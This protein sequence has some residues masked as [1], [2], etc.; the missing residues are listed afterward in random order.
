MAKRASYYH[1]E[2]NFPEYITVNVSEGKYPEIVGTYFRQWDPDL[3]R[4]YYVKCVDFPKQEYYLFR[5]N[6]L[7]WTISEQYETNYFTIYYPRETENVLSCSSNWVG[8]SK[9]MCDKEVKVSINK[10]G[11]KPEKIVSNTDVSTQTD[12]TKKNSKHKRKKEKQQKNKVLKVSEN[13]TCSICFEEVGVLENMCK[14][15]CKH[16]FHSECILPWLLKN[17]N[18]PNCRKVVITNH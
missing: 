11:F 6:D 15:P 10:L 4:M 2:P 16:T 1:M 3:N 17:P 18:C 9:Y 7:M 13:P 12:L 8:S 14:L 5:G